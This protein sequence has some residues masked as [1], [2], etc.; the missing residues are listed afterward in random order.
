MV[1]RAEG[2]RRLRTRPDDGAAPEQVVVGGRSVGS[3]RVA[4]PG[5]LRA[6]VRGEPRLQE[7]QI[8]GIG[9]PGRTRQPA[10]AVDRG[11]R[12]SAVVDDVPKH[13]EV[14]LDLAPAARSGPHQPPT[15]V[16]DVVADQGVQ[17]PTG[18]GRAPGAADTGGLLG[19]PV[20]EHDSGAR[21][22]NP[23]AELV[24]E[25]V[26]ER[27][28]ETPAVDH[29]QAGRV[30]AASRSR[31]RRGA[32]RRQH[33]SALIADRRT[34]AVERVLAEHPHH[35]GRLLP[36]WQPGE[37]GEGGLL[38]AHH[39]VDPVGLIVDEPAVQLLVEQQKLQ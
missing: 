27:H 33:G 37:I 17:G 35:V 34:P 21:N 26:D 20:V 7:Q 11:L 30:G 31:S 3:H 4:A 6:D 39:Q 28:H 9:K 10:G 13:L 36:S 22:H 12:A 23:G 1:G 16:D 18:P 14:G 2:L 15:A 5:Q 25:T 8:L 19:Q 29:R 24:E 32:R 38:A